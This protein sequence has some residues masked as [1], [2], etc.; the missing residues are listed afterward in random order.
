V[1]EGRN[2]NDTTYVAVSGDSVLLYDSWD[3]KSPSTVFL[4]PLVDGASWGVQSDRTNVRVETDVPSHIGT[5]AHAFSVERWARE[6]FNST[7]ESNVLVASG[8]G[9]VRWEKKETNLGPVVH[10]MWDLIRYKREG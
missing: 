3:A 9:I 6:G 7:L 8:V 2:Y 1:Y 10:Q 4:F 5:L